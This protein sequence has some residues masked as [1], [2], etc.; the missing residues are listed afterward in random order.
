MTDRGEQQPEFN[1]SGL[2][3]N[4]PNQPLLDIHGGQDG[5]P[6]VSLQQETEQADPVRPYSEVKGMHDVGRRDYT[7]S[8]ASTPPTRSRCFSRIGA[9]TSS[10]NSSVCSAARP[11]NSW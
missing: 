10:R 1:I 3:H 11:V 9:T 4:Q 6:V 2:R 7:L 5:Q 8:E